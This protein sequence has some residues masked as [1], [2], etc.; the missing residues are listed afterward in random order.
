MKSF[1]ATVVI[2]ATFSQPSW[3]KIE[4]FEWNMCRDELQSLNFSKKHDRWSV[5]LSK[6]WFLK[7]SRLDTRLPTFVVQRLVRDGRQ[8]SPDVANDC[9]Y[10]HR[11]SPSRLSLADIFPFLRRTGAFAMRQLRRSLEYVPISGGCGAEREARARRLVLSVFI[12]RSRPSRYWVNSSW[13]RASP[14]S[15]SRHRVARFFLA[16]L[17]LSLNRYLSLPLQSHGNLITHSR[18]DSTHASLLDKAR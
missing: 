3:M 11:L 6:Y 12:L 8:V 16:H 17:Q 7:V 10:L 4:L 18:D 14:Q 9:H 5:Y 2:W 15:D 1:Y 13:N